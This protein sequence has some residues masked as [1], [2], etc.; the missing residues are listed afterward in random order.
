MKL[1]YIE[2]DD[3]HSANGWHTKEEVQQFQDEVPTIKQ[4]GWVF[5]ET[6]RY[7]TLVSRH[8]PNN[9]FGEDPNDE[10]FGHLQRIPKPWIQKRVDLTEHI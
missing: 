4:V 3:A 8:A 9:L 7:I 6:K 2:W 1:I 10:A 5:E